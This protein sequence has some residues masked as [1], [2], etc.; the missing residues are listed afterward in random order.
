MLA[1]LLG[2]FLGFCTGELSRMLRMQ[3]LAPTPWVAVPTAVLIYAACTIIILGKASAVYLLPLPLLFLILF[4]ISIFR[5]SHHAFGGAAA[6]VGGI[7]YLLAG[8]LSFFFAG[9]AEGAYNPWLP[10]GLLLLIWMNDTFAYLTGSFLG[11]TKLLLHISSGKTWEGAAGGLF[12]SFLVSLLYSYFLEGSITLPWMILG[13]LVPPIAT[14]GDLVESQLKRYAGVKDSGNILPGHGGF[15]DR[16]D[17]LIAVGPI[18]A[19]VLHLFAR[20]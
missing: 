17:S 13:L 6:T 4:V 16:L 11:R 2:I 5:R 19:A 7:S 15:L 8:F 3:M 12:F 9:Y 20:M 10:L 18:G 1:A 14:L